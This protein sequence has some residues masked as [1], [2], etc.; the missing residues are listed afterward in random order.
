M[1]RPRTTMALAVALLAGCSGSKPTPPG[2]G[3]DAARGTGSGP[4]GAGGSAGAGSG[5]RA[6]AAAPTGTGGGGGAAGEVDAA[7]GGMADAV[8]GGIDGGGGAGAVDAAAADLRPARDATALPDGPYRYPDPAGMLCGDTRH[9]LA[10]TPAQVMLVLDRSTSMD[11]EIA[12]F[13]TRTKWDEATAAVKEALAAN[14]QIAWGLKL[15][16]GSPGRRQYRSRV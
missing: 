5:G 16:L 12:L 11:E 9:T 8:A 10:K 4:G 7:V 1:K 15:F 13:P 3:R 14:P 6:D 2:P